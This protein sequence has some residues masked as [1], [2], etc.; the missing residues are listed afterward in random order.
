MDVLTVG[1]RGKRVE[2]QV[3]V[4]LKRVKHARWVEIY[5][6]LVSSISVRRCTMVYLALSG[7]DT[8]TLLIPLHYAQ[9]QSQPHQQEW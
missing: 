5:H 8:Q 2:R 9:G 7:W 1:R 4:R 6:D 3:F